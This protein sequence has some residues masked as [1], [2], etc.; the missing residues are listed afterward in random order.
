[1]QHTTQILNAKLNLTKVVIQKLNEER[2]IQLKGQ[3]YKK[4]CT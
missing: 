2:D 4:M 1:M 3:K